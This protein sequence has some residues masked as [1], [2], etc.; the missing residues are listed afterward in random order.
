MVRGRAMHMC[1]S[2]ADV[3]NLFIGLDVDE[4]SFENKFTILIKIL[5]VLFTVLYI[6]KFVFNNTKDCKSDEPNLSHAVYLLYKTAKHASSHKTQSQLNKI[7]EKTYHNRRRRPKLHLDTHYCN[8]VSAPI[9]H[10]ARA[11]RSLIARVQTAN[12]I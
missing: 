6:V 9:D 2:C 3:A 8:S 11:Y 7:N 1:D 4:K 5:L 10:G 12:Q